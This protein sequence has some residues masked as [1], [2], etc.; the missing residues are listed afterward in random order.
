M[1][2]ILSLNYD[3]YYISLNLQIRPDVEYFIDMDNEN[4][5]F[6]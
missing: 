4:E 6:I 2:F 1:F 3:M 5:K